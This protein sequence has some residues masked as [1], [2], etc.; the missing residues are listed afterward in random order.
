MTPSGSR[1]SQSR[2]KGPGAEALRALGIDP[3]T[4]HALSPEPRT[5]PAGPIAACVERS[6][7][8]FEEFVGRVEGVAGADLVVV[9]ED[10][11]PAALPRCFG[12]IGLETWLIQI[13][14]VRR[15]IDI[16]MLETMRS[17]ELDDGFGVNRELP[18]HRL[19]GPED[20]WREV[21][22][23]EAR[24]LVRARD[25]FGQRYVRSMMSPSDTGKPTIWSRRLRGDSGQVYAFDRVL[26]L[27]GTAIVALLRGED[28]SGFAAK[29][30]SAHRFPVEQTGERFEREGRLLASLEHPNV[31]RVVDRATLDEGEPVLVLEYLPG[32]SVY[33]RL[34]ESG[35][36]SLS[37]ALRWL[38]DALSGLAAMHARN[39]V[40]RDVSPKNLLFRENGELVVGDFGTARHLDD[41]TLTASADR[42]GSL[43]YIAP[44]QLRAAHLAGPEADVY[45]IG[46]IGFQ[47]LT[48]LTPLGNTG[49]VSRHA[50]DVPRRISSAVEA[51]RAYRP[52]DRPAD[53]GTALK[54]LGVG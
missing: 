1:R 41:A 36:P 5:D 17:L 25:E 9:V 6:Q 50:P 38:G 23:G 32:G 19:I 44:E 39:V 20:D 46:Q 49:P 37:M 16:A 7:P 40:H 54:L 2:A 35:P 27:G 47:L 26:G 14:C 15:G 34:A 51:M 29:A 18:G 8:L 48:G 13:E 31:V 33:S 42:I 12:A 30:L 11:D 10:D 24:R 21:V 22:D 45:S 53:A 52:E 28:G 4:H 3:V 43:I